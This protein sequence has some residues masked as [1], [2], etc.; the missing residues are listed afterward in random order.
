MGWKQH[1]VLESDGGKLGDA[2]RPAVRRERD[3]ED[4]ARPGLAQEQGIAEHVD[5]GGAARRLMP[6]YSSSSGIFAFQIESHSSIKDASVALRA[7]AESMQEE[8]YK[9]L[10]PFYLGPV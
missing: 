3:G 4:G 8:V 7:F 6:S 2:P 9:L 5:A 10:H 1:F